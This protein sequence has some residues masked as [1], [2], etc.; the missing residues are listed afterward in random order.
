MLKALPLPVHLAAPF[1]LA[2]ALA[3]DL[4]GTGD[5]G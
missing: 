5:L 4:R 3:D 2:P 1:A